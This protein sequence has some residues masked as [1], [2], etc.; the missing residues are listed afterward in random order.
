MQVNAALLRFLPYL[1]NGLVLV[2]LVNDL[3]DHLRLMLDQARIGRRELGAMDGIAR[4]IFEQERQKR[5]DAA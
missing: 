3:G 4:G 1:R 2:C 5:G